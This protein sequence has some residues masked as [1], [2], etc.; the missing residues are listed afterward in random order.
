M[1]NRKNRKKVIKE[2]QWNHLPVV[3][4]EI[5]YLVKIVGEGGHSGH[6]DQRSIRVGE[7]R[8]GW[9]MF[10]PS[11]VEIWIMEVS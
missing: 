6:P 2:F 5:D 8:H 11:R 10:D 3:R 9:L 4:E 1:K 7:S